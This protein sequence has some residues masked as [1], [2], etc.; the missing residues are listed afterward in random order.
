MKKLAIILIS[1]FFTTSAQ[2]LVFE[3]CFTTNK[4]YEI[5]PEIRKKIETALG[6]KVDTSGFIKE[7]YVKY[8]F[9]FALDKGKVMETKILT[10]EWLEKINKGKSNKSDKIQTNFYDI[11]FYDEKFI[12]AEVIA[13]EDSVA[14]STDV[15]TFDL[16]NGTVFKQVKVTILSSGREVNSD[17]LHSYRK[18]D[19]KK[20]SSYNY[21]DYWWAVILI[22]AITFFI[23]TQSGKRLKKIRRK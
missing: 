15:L 3:K 20:I 11:T 13:S 9:D 5:T 22:I 7:A 2:A 10:D 16:S 1:I 14:R 23:F 19:F 21:L 18:C 4:N 12:K 6:K 17:I 8:Q